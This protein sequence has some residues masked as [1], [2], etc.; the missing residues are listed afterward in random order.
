[1]SGSTTPIRVC[2]HECALV[3]GCSVGGL[4]C[5]GCGRYFCASDLDQDGYC[6]RCAEEREDESEDEDDD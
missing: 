3:N 2:D 6:D 4:T 1:M 5:E